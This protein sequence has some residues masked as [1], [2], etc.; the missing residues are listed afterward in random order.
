MSTPEKG[1]T[2]PP[3]AMGLAF[4]RPSP[5]LET[6]PGRQSRNI[7]NQE[8]SYNE[9]SLGLGIQIIFPESNGTACGPEFGA[10]SPLKLNNLNGGSNGTKG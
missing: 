9:H 5:P 3:Q 4:P 7:P 6:E 1:Y 2:V 8:S 10:I